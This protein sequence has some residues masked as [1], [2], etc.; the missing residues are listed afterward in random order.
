[1]TKISVTRHE[2]RVIIS[3]RFTFVPLLDSIQQKSKFLTLVE[4]IHDLPFE[5]MQESL[6]FFTIQNKIL[7]K[8]TIDG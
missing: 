4:N 7:Q 2:S 1:M 8:P 5:L 3:M 6:I